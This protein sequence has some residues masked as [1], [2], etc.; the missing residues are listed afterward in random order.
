[1]GV[2]YGVAFPNAGAI[3]GALPPDTHRAQLLTATDL[4]DPL[5]AVDRLMA[6]RHHAGDLGEEGLGAIV[7]HLRPDADFVADPEA[8][9]RAAR[10]RLDEIC[11]EQV[12]ALATL[13]LNRR[14]CVTG[15]AGTGK[16]HL[17]TEW[18]RRA[19]RRGERVLLTCFNQPLAGD[20]ARRLGDLDVTV[21]TFHDVARSLDGMPA[22]DI[23]DG[24]GGQWWDTV[25]LG[26][27][28]SNWRLV[29][30][31]FDTIIV[32]EAQDLSPA[33]I[34]MLRQLLDP[35]G[36]RR[37]LLLADTS[38]EIYRRGFDEPSADDGWTRCELSN[39]CRNTHAIASIIRRRFDGPVA[40]VAG[41]ESE[42]VTWVE[43]DAGAE[44]AAVA[45]VGEA[46]DV[47]LD[48]RDHQP[49]TMLVATT[50]GSVRD[51]LIDEYGFARWETY[52]DGTI[53]CENIHR[54]KGLEF[55]HVILVVPEP[56]TADDLLYVGV[57]RAVISLT[58][59]GPSAIADR[60]GL[61]ARS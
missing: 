30:D 23:P 47:V 15:G 24:A 46:I 60:L 52:T 25:M 10:R 16:S 50:T 13:D 39:N 38:Q 34:T 42:A 18:A 9:I 36:P 31:R 22:I 49:D 7:R 32:D 27:L 54:V 19:N 57:S 29:T 17:A 61:R 58:V 14:V 3:D 11:R 26:H 51:R 45:E 28:H 21:G 41:P 8:R 55:D 59:I 1:M 33:W 12:Q 20:L 56:G 4:E 43:I 2:E 53:L 5:D 44:G 6:T 48:D 37:M 40:P 35:D